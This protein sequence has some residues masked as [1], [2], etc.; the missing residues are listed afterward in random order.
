[1]ISL[2]ETGSSASAGRGIRGATGV[3][4]E[5]SAVALVLFFAGGF[6]VASLV[7]ESEDWVADEGGWAVDVDGAPCFERIP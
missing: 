6:L 1:V 2:D 5:G 3:D 4:P 7:T